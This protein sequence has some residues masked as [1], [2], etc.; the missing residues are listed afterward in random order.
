MGEKL[1]K[2]MILSHVSAKTQASA[3]GGSGYR[4]STVGEWQSAQQRQ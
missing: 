3:G 2:S 1:F 4:W